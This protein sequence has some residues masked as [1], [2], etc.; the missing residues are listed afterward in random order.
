MKTRTQAGPRVLHFRPESLIIAAIL[1]FAAYNLKKR[2]LYMDPFETP[3]HEALEPL[4]NPKAVAVIGATN[5]WNKWGF[6]TFASILN[7]YEGRVYPINSIETEVL[8]HPV[9]RRVTDIPEDEPVD[10]AVFVIPPQGVLSTMAD[11]VAKGIKAGLVIT[12]GFAETGEEGR[13]LQ[14]R[15][16]GIARQGPL[17][18]IGPNCMGYWSASSNL[19]AFM[20]PLPAR[21]GRIAFVT[22]GGNVGG[23]VM[24][25]AY[26]RG[27]GF[28]R[29]ISCGCTADIPLEDYIE[30]FGQDPEVEVILAY[31]EGVGD[32]Q[33]FI[34]KVRRVTPNKPVIA[35]KPGRTPAGT[36]AIASHSGALA[37]SS[38]LY[39]SAFR[40]A[41]VIRV[42]TAE[43]MIDLAIGF[44]SQPLPRGN[45][46]AI[47]TPGGSYGV[48]SADACASLGLN[49]IKLSDETIA[50]FDK[51]FPPR[52]SRGNPVDPAGDRNFIAYMQAP[53]ML[54]KLPEV[55]AMIFMGFD[56]FAN[57]SSVFVQISQKLAQA[58]WTLIEELEAM[59]P[60]DEEA[61]APPGERPEWA[62]RLI[63]RVV[64][65]FFSFFGTSDS[66][67]VAEF[68][69]RQIGFLQSE[70]IGPHL[71][72]R[73]KT[74]LGDFRQGGVENIG[75]VFG[76][77]FQPILES[78]VLNWI[79]TYKKPVLTTSFMGQPPAMSKLGHYAY[80][81]AEQAALVLAKLLEYQRYLDRQEK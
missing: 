55:D 36:K 75:A 32:G 43:A 21:P 41:G 37:G 9:Y 42:D 16:I 56:S 69:R 70:R 80:P 61:D 6:S 5:K 48:I 26:D 52:W 14:D 20:F 22:Q 10:L 31:I 53:E 79:D 35:L 74:I 46:L 38:D 40:K 3:V 76:Q 51:I 60:K 17:R 58:M 78:L 15:L 2:G 73:L 8:G 71:I 12:A 29:Y 34:E 68:G 66:A 25:M 44:L 13:R 4:F 72:D 64:E 23:A 30:H 45:N 19:R 77:V 27:L 7:G 39:D 54:L 62:M 57:F 24:R 59:V 49:V 65:V 1:V 33:R 63:A 67:E 18:F 11:C 81:F 28:H 47:I 50:E